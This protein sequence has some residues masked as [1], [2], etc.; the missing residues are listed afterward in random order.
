MSRAQEVLDAIDGALSDWT[1]SD[2]AMRWVPTER[3]RRADAVRHDAVRRHRQQR[4]DS[5]VIPS[6]GLALRTAEDMERARA[7]L[8]AALEANPE[9]LEA[10]RED[11]RRLGVF[12]QNVLDAIRPVAEQVGKSYAEVANQ[13]ATAIAEVGRRQEPSG[14]PRPSPSLREVDPAAYALQCR[15][16]RGTGPNHQVQRERRPRTIR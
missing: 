12:A 9:V 1:V 3:D 14:R 5:L 8:R 10:F 16:T 13:W 15:Q 7:N 4:L 6:V 2:D 11:L